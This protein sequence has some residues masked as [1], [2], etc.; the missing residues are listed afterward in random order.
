MGMF[1][2]EGW[3]RVHTWVH[4]VERDDAGYQADL[5]IY[6]SLITGLWHR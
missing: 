2:L 1:P 3:G 6:N 4:G 5:Q